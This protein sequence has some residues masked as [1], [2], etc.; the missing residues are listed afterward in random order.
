MNKINLRQLIFR[1]IFNNNLRRPV[2]AA[3]LFCS[4]DTA[5]KPEQTPIVATNG[6][7]LRLFLAREI[8]NNT[9][10][11]FQFQTM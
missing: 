5:P 3:R 10:F 11:S 8:Q 9:K 7:F 4:S 2:S 6:Q 1:N